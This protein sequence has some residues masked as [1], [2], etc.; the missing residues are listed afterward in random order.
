MY[1]MSWAMYGIL[2]AMYGIL[3]AMYGAATKSSLTYPQFWAAD[4]VVGDVRSCDKNQIL[5]STSVFVVGNVRRHRQ[6]L[7]L[8]E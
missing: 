6:I 1:G 3:W 4:S 7:G 5:L 2:W 8:R